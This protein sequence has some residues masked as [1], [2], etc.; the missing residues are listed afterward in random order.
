MR[1]TI[2]TMT[3]VFAV[4][5]LSLGLALTSCKKGDTGPAGPSG[6]N[7]T[8]GVS[9][10]KTNIFTTNTNQWNLDNIHN[11]YYY[12]YSSTDITSDVL[13]NGAVMVYLGDGTGNTWTAMPFSIQGGSLAFVIGQSKVQI[14]ASLFDGSVPNNPGG[15]Q[16]K[17]VIIPPTMVKPN[18]NT[19]NYADV[20][21]AYNLV[22]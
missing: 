2:K 3:M 20:K 10:I 13:S 4:G 19:N 8:N 11:V 15:Q 14:Q 6:T 22:D 12:N 5:A 21:E 7:G 17:V 18:V 1:K 16:F 9:N